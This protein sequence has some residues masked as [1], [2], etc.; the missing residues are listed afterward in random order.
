M[1]I[2]VLNLF[3]KEK[4]LLIGQKWGNVVDCPGVVGILLL[5]LFPQDVFR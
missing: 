5:M 1:V 4:S 3:L 2:V